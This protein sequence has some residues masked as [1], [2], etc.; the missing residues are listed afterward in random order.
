M[1]YQNKIANNW[2]NIDWKKANSK[3]AD[4]QYEV[5]K[6]HRKGDESLVLTT[7]HALIRSFAARCLLMGYKTYLVINFYLLDM[8]MTF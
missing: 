8:L 4:L 7:Q 6:A 3:L 1:N 5:L 2:A